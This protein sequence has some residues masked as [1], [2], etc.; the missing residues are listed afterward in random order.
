MGRPRALGTMAESAV[1]AFLRDNGFLQAERRSLHGSLD[2]GDVT[3]TPG[4]CWEVKYANGGIRMGA[5]VAQT[6]IERLNSKSDFGILVIKPRGRGVRT[7][8]LW[9]A[10][11]SL[12]GHEE[13]CAKAPNFCQTLPAVRY[14]AGSLGLALDQVSFYSWPTTAL[15]VVPPGAFDLPQGHYRVMRFKDMVKLLRA[16][17]YGDPLASVGRPIETAPAT[18]AETGHICTSEP[19][20]CPTSGEVESACHGGFDVCCDRPDLHGPVSGAP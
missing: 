16:A 6:E 7:T 19:Y 2:Q 8:G 5:W 12:P 9:Y 11:M 14:T 13:L 15:T 18:L 1:V 4:L 17:G 20:F 10:V 3:G